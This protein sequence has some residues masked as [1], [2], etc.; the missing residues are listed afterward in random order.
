VKLLLDQDLSRKLVKALS[1]L[2][3]GSVHVTACGL[4]NA[5]DSAIWSHAREPGFAILTKDTDFHQRCFLYGAPPKAVWIRLGNCTT[6]NIEALL[7]M[8]AAEVV[9][10][11]EDKDA[12][13]L[14]LP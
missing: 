3:P 9:A 4:E 12:A 1:R 10:F 8:R 14:V 6:S 11:G 5:D 2:Y 13:L 7:R